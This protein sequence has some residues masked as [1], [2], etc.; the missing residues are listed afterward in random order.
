MNVLHVATL[1]R[2]IRQD[3]GYGP[4][5]TVV[6][7][8]D[9]GLHE[10]GHRSIVACSGDSQVT[11]EQ[12]TT[13]KKSFSEYCTDHTLVKQKYM[14]RHLAL[15]LQRAQRGDI[16][17]IHMHDADMAEYMFKGVWQ[18]PVPIV[19]TLHVPADDHGGFTRWNETLI[20]SSSA[21]FVPISEFQRSQHQ[22]LINGQKVIH[23]GIDV[24]DYPFNIHS[25]KHDYLFSIGRITQ[26]KGPDIAI[27]VA[28]KTGS[29]LILAGNVQNKENDRKFFKKLKHSIDLVADVAQPFTGND[30]Y[31]D[32]MKP[33]LDSD[34][35]I[36][37]I[38]EVGS[39]Q[40]KLWYQHAKATLFPIQW[41]EPFGLVLIES[42]ACGTPVLAFHKGSVPEI[43]VHGKTGFVVDSIDHM[44]EAVKAIH[45]IDP[46]DCRQH[47]KDNFS[48]AS[49]AGKYSELYQWIVDERTLC[50]KTSPSV[51]G[52]SF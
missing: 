3:L 35:Q 11:G 12:F 51:T 38:G 36:I 16:D 27:E 4:I 43:V 17:I 2:P 18:T 41:G 29:R 9:K 32:V 24:E 28:R 15:S 48:I 37:Y 46:G 44:T 30:Y 20:S 1:N 50:L 5:E 39:A 14:D 7:N 42:M 25:S 31:Q 6:Y 8:L 33:I 22:G 21:Y 19:M 34:K 49:M 10:L 52:L 40:K 26:D 23:H 45:L 13:I 47:V